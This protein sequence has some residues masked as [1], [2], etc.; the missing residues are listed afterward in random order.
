MPALP[1]EIEWR[2]FASRII[3]AEKLPHGTELRLYKGEARKRSHMKVK[4]KGHIRFAKARLS[5]NERV[6]D[7]QRIIASSLSTELEARKLDIRVFGPD[8]KRIVGNTH[9][10]TLRSMSPRPTAADIAEAEMRAEEIADAQFDAEAAI[11]KLERD[12]T[13]AAGVVCPAVVR[14][15]VE[16]FGRDRVLEC[17]GDAE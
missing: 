15:L 5:D 13:D 3:N 2:D 16:R 17:L 12:A 9:I 1:L 10:S 7:L 11:K 14:A 4:V 8:G 6:S